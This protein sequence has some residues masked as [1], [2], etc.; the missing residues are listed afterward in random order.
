MAQ[1]GRFSLSDYVIRI[2]SGLEPDV[3][4]NGSTILSTERSAELADQ[5]RDLDLARQRAEAESREYRVS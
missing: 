3:D 4:V 1:I 2:D 5:L